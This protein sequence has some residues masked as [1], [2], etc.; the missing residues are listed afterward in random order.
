MPFAIIANTSQTSNLTEWRNFTG[1]ILASIAG[2]GT[3]QIGTAPALYAETNLSRVG[4]GTTNLTGFRLQVAGNIGPNSAPVNSS[5]AQSNVTIDRYSAYQFFMAIAPDGTPVIAYNIDGTPKVAKCGNANCTAG[6]TLTVADSASSSVALGLSITIGSDGMPVMIYRDNGGD[7]VKI[8]K[9]G[10]LACS[11]GNIITTIEGGGNIGNSARSSI[12]IGTDGFPILAYYNGTGAGGLRV[13]K[14]GNLACSSGNT[15]T[16]VQ[17]SSSV[18]E[19]SIAIAPD[20]LPIV[21]YGDGNVGYLRIAKCGNAACSSGNVIEEARDVTN[22]LGSTQSLAIGSDGLAVMFASSGDDLWVVKCNNANCSSR[23]YTTIDSTGN[24]GSQSSIAIGTDGLPVVSYLDNTNN[25]LK[26]AKCGNLACSSGNTITNLSIARGDTSIAIGTDG[27]PVIVTANATNNGVVVIKCANPA[28]SATT[29]SSFSGGSQLG[30]WMPNPRSYGVPFE[31]IN[32]IQVAN[33]TTFRNLA[34]LVAGAERLTITPSGTIG[35]SITKPAAA[36]HINSTLSTGAL[37]VENTTG[38]SLLFVNGTSGSVGIGTTVPSSTLQVTGNATITGN[39]STSKLLPGTIEAPL[40]S[41]SAPTYT[42]TGDTNTGIY[43]TTGDTIDFTIGGERKLS[44]ATSGDQLNSWQNIAFQSTISSN[45]GYISAASSHNVIDFLDAGSA[46][47]IRIASTSNTFTSPLFLIAPNAYWNGAT[48]EHTAELIS[49]NVRGLPSGAQGVTVGG[50]YATQRQVYIQ[51]PTYDGDDTSRTIT[52]AYGMYVDSPTSGSNMNIT[53]MYGLAAGSSATTNATASATYS[54]IAV[55]AHTITDSSTTQ[56]TSSPFA[57]GLSIGQITLAQSGGAVTIDNA[58]SLYIAA[59]PTTGASVTLTNPYALWV[60]AGVSRFDGNVG[61]GTASPNVTLH[62]NGSGTGSGGFLVTNGSQALFYANVSSGRIGV[63]T[64]NMTDMLTIRGNT[65]S[66]G[67]IINTPANPVYL[68]GIDTGNEGIQDIFVAGRYAYVVKASNVTFCNSTASGG[69]E[70]QIF[71]VSNPSSP[72]YLGGA[73]TI[74][75]PNSVYASGRYVYV[76]KDNNG[77]A[78]SPANNSGCELQ[79]YDVS[80][81]SGPAFVGGADTGIG[82]N[83]EVYVSGRYAYFA[84]VRNDGTCTSTDRTGCELQIYDV[85]N[86]ASPA[87]VGGA[88]TGPNQA[89]SVQVYG[90]YAYVAADINTGACTSTNNTGCEF[91]IYDVSNPS[92]PTFVSGVDTINAPNHAYASGRYAYVTK[93]GD[94]GTCSTTNGTG[95][96]LQIYDVSN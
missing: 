48:T 88:T 94:S 82:G 87:F 19:V 75:T 89:F 24:V 77:N 29:G 93:G 58:A 73:D 54:A 30:G 28:C 59:A 40:G 34:F 27:L 2:T 14:C 79:I 31:T 35:I 78:C 76:G 91:Q 33:P 66:D 57:A 80:N 47:G 52:N 15:I 68:G 38:Q 7:T 37:R 56:V 65:L 67:S 50:S 4:I 41:A 8:A 26:V 83:Y 53:N 60:D 64:T 84:G 20:G 21:S 3:L 17:T 51:Q 46:Y 11:S 90:R 12:A 25:N 74:N 49:L 95:C 70:F 10:N 42:F 61:I 92:N 16:A 18:T 39:L 44:I 9:C 63:G 13:A 72:A 96:E 45:Q 62:V 36:L 86:P 6:N 32:T 22:A 55:P 69:C 5:I 23:N 81:I 85:S 1:T 71:D 43:S